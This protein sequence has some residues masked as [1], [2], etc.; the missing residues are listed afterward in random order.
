MSLHTLITGGPATGKTTLARAAATAH[1]ASGGRVLHGFSGI[2]VGRIALDG[3]PLLVVIDDWDGYD[4]PAII[5][6]PHPH[7]VCAEHVDDDTAD[8]FDL[9]VHLGPGSL[10]T[11]PAKRQTTDGG[12]KRRDR[13]VKRQT[14]DGRWE[15]VEPAD[16]PVA[17]GTAGMG[18]QEPAGACPATHRAVGLAEV[19]TT[20]AVARS[21][22]LPPSAACPQR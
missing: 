22:P 20:W 11:E 10:D 7:L 5:R 9:V 6:S 3:T 13:I 19:E 12:C 2:P 21:E 17:G 18:S 4:L 15:T 8:A 16:E 1:R 14:S